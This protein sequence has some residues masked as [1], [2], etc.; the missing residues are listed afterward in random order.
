MLIL[1]QWKSG[2]MLCSATSNHQAASAIAV[3]LRCHPAESYHT[4]RSGIKRASASARGLVA[5]VLEGWH[6]TLLGIAAVSKL[7]GGT[8]NLEMVVEYDDTR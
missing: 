8:W 7:C 4:A 5:A 1:R 2:W 3:E 6:Y